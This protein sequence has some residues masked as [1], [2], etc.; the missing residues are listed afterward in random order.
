MFRFPLRTEQMARESKI[1]SVLYHWKKLDTMME[2]LKKRVLPVFHFSLH[3]ITAS[4]VLEQKPKFLS[5]YQDLLPGSPHIFLHEQV[6]RSIFNDAATLRSSVLKTLDP[7]TFAAN[8]PQTLSRERFG[9]AEFVQWY[10]GQNAVPHQRWIF[11]VWEFFHEIVRD[12]LSD[13]QMD[14]ERKVLQIKVVLGPLFDWSILPVTETRR[15]QRKTP[16]SRLS[17]KS[18]PNA[19]HFLVPLKHASSVLDFTNPDSASLK[20]VRRLAKLGPPELNCSPLSATSSGISVYSSSNSVTLARMLVSVP[21]GSRI[22]SYI[23]STK[24]DFRPTFNQR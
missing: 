21:E 7:G 24:D 15:I 13:A 20:L 19:E 8:L 22:T 6:C 17:F 9:K 12:V 16:L 14:E 23:T 3:K 1:S 18:P 10:P 4:I 5:R 2:E 11:R